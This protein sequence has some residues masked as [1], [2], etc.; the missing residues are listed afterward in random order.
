METDKGT[1]PVSLWL[2][3]VSGLFRSRDVS[4]IAARCYSCG[5]WDEI[6]PATIALRTGTWLGLLP[7]TQH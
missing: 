7:L 1:A 5:E 4:V 2:C 6:G 3:C